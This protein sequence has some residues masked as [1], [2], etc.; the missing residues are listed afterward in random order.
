[1]IAQPEK[2]SEHFNTR[3]RQ[4]KW[5]NGSYIGCYRDILHSPPVWRGLDIKE[6][7]TFSTNE[8]LLLSSFACNLIRF[9]NN[10]PSELKSNLLTEVEARKLDG[11]NGK[12]L[13]NMTANVGLS[14]IDIL[15]TQPILVR[16]AFFYTICIKGFPQGHYFTSEAQQ[17][18]VALR[19]GIK[20]EFH[21]DKI[22]NGKIVNALFRLDFV[23][24][25][26]KS[27]VD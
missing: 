4:I 8:L 23:E 9:G 20:V 15:F 6:K 22:V 26:H 7:T 16:P 19:N 13:L 24:I 12:V 3:P 2:E 1:M 21:K 18:S 17:S 10:D 11:A 5:G 25:T 14:W 27:I